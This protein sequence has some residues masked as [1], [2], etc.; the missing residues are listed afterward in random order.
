MIKCIEI[1]PLISSF[2]HDPHTHRPNNYFLL[3]KMNE[4]EQEGHQIITITRY[5]KTYKIF[6]REKT[7]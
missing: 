2:T 4:L 7:T 1:D 3:Y 5:K 6:Y